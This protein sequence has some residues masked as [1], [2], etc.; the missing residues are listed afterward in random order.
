MGANRSTLF[1]V[2][3]TSYLVSYLVG[4]RMGL[5]EGSFEALSGEIALQ[6]KQS[7]KF[8]LDPLKPYSAIAPPQIT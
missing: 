7:C 2:D 3:A 5:V 6:S 1:L 4:R 8:F